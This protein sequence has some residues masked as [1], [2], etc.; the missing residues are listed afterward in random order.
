V[1]TKKPSHKVKTNN[2]K[3]FSRQYIKQFLPTNPVII[4][5]GAHIGRDTLKIHKLWPL[6]TI[7][8]FEPVPILFDQLKIAVAD[9]PNVHCYQLALSDHTGTETLYVSDAQHTAISS[10]FKPAC[11][12]QEKPSVH[13]TPIMVNTITLDDWAEK[14]NVDHVDFMWLDMQGAELQALQV[15]PKVLKNVKVLLI[16]VSLTERYKDN[17]LY[18]EV[19]SWLEKQGF[20]LELEHL[21]HGTWGNALF[22]HS[23]K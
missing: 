12:A 19:K 9:K 1:V 21:H 4:E 22:I 5:A 8:A 6:S 10:L 16:E 3:Q 15:A 17:P 14:Y 13:F 18:N 7:H 20:L 23:G 2:N 11:I